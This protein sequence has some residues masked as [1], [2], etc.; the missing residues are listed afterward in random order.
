MKIRSLLLLFLCQYVCAEPQT[1]HEELL[2]IAQ[3]ADRVE[4][5]WRPEMNVEAVGL[6]SLKKVY[7]GSAIAELVS[8]IEF[9]AD[10][11]REPDPEPD[12][13]VDPDAIIIEAPNCRCDGSHLLR[14]SLPG[15]VTIDVSFHHGTHLRSKLLYHGRDAYLTEASQHWL[16]SQADWEADMSKIEVLKREKEQTN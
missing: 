2:Q 11:P 7:V 5:T 13:P 14:F 4:L 9:I 6:V 1:L 15:Q 3:Q 10:Q 8:H 16:Q 12:P